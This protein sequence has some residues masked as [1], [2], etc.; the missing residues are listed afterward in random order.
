M[1]GIYCRISGDKEE[2][3]DTSIETQ[4][5]KGIDFANKLG[6]PYKLYYDIGISGTS[7]E[8]RDD[9]SR[10]ITDIKNGIVKDIFAINQARLERDL[11]TWRMFAATVLNA[12]AKWYPNGNYYELEDTTNRM[13]ANMLSLINEFHAQNTSDAVK[14][15]FERNA[16]MGKVHGIRPYGIMSDENGYMIHEPNEIKVVK[17]IFKWSLEGIGAY[18]IAKKLNKS[19]V[20]TRYN[21]LNKST[22]RKDA[23]TGAVINHSNRK[24]W[25]TTVY[26]ILK[27]KLYAGVHLWN[28]EEIDLPHLAIISKEDYYQVQENLKENKRTKSGKRPMYKYLLNGLLFCEECGHMYKGKRRLSD[29]RNQYICSGKQAPLHVCKSGKGFNIPRFETFI[30]KHLFLNKNLQAYLNS[31]EVDTVEID[32]L[33]FKKNEL[34]KKLNAAERLESRTFNL[35]L[36]DDLTDD[37][38]LKDNYKEAQGKVKQLKASLKLVE[39][40]LRIQTDNNRLSRVN[41]TIEGFDVNADFKAIKQAVQQLIE[42][43]D[44]HYHAL[45]KNGI[46]RFKIKYKGFNETIQY[47]TNQQLMNYVCTSHR[48]ENPEDEHGL[49]MVEKLIV[50]KSLFR[51]KL[52][53]VVKGPLDVQLKRDELIVFD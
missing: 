15:A 19:N 9:F 11:D 8:K 32:T 24:W 13:L 39:T 6:K 43:I 36:D 44:V 20:P 28:G 16:K 41:K 42:R 48:K 50:R 47:S 12:G 51:H 35:L 49:T 26:G 17:D 21:K 38:R 45:D 18:T 2:G 30:I 23:D 5:K 29:R 10:F 40:D 31:I 22:R 52:S 46:F 27:K 7:Y 3:K 37:Q 33:S 25:G 34:Q 53:G 4:E 1:V 14:V